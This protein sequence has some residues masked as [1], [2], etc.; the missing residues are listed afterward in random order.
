MYFILQG[1]FKYVILH[2]DKTNPMVLRMRS[3]VHNRRLC[4]SQWQGETGAGA[5]VVLGWAGCCLNT[6][7]ARAWPETSQIILNHVKNSE[8]KLSL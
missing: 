5:P 8:G 4:E 3:L 2:N 6:E 1:S 7:E